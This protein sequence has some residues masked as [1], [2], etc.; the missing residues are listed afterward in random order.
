[1]KIEGYLDAFVKNSSK[2][3][4]KNINIY[5]PIANRAYL[6]VEPVV[7]GK[8]KPGLK[9]DKFDN[10][11]LRFRIKELRH[12]EQVTLTSFFQLETKK[13]DKE[14]LLFES[15]WKARKK[16]VTLIYPEGLRRIKKIAERLYRKSKLLMDFEEEIA[17]FIERNFRVSKGEDEENLETL[18]RN[19]RGNIETIVD[20]IIALHKNVSIPA[21]KVKGVLFL[22]EKNEPIEHYWIEVRILGE[23]VPIDA[24]YYNFGK[25]EDKYLA[26]RVIEE[27]Q[28]G[29]EVKSIYTLSKKYI[30]RALIIG[31]ERTYRRLI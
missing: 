13:L 15:L 30:K 21:R 19:N 18:L 11:Y 5:F 20:F 24:I 17:G 7:D 23:W 10:V 6:D 8:P 2:A 16:R 27:L 31:F 12:G 22:N 9:K 3:L 1:M 29:P 26:I 4:A 25:F 14:N 28:E